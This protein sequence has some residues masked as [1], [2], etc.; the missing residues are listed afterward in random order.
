MMRIEAVIHVTMETRGAVE[1]RAYTDKHAVNEPIRSI[2]S[3]RSTVIWRVIEISIRT[4]GRNPDI[5][6]YRDL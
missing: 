6:A 5:H 4:D 1:P 3:I 2:V